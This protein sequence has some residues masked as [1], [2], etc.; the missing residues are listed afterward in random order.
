MIGELAEVADGDINALVRG[1]LQ[2]SINSDLAAEMDA[3]LGY[4]SGDR[5]GKVAAGQSNSRNG[6]YSKTV[7]THYE[8][9][10]IDIPRDRD[11]TYI[12]RMV[13]KGARRITQL[14]DMIVSL[15]AGG[16]TVRDIQHHIATSYGVDMSHETI[17]N[18]TDS[19]LEAVLE[20]Q[21]RRLDA[22]YPIMFLDAIRINVRDG[23]RVINK[24]AHIAVGI[25]LGGAKH[26]L[27]IWVAAT[28]G[29][30]PFGRVCAQNLPT[31]VSRTCSLLPATGSK[32]YQRR[33]KRPGRTHWC[34]PVSCT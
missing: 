1:A 4:R 23:G 25:D 22:F 3:H 19:V 11:S 8:P 20:W 14:D 7:D 26:I 15:Y 10:D 32:A 16:M 5:A 9:I 2:S 17:S 33:S 18:V 31:V 6:S 29:A 30:P 21:H 34:K 28:E 13:P 12:P 24:A 27:G